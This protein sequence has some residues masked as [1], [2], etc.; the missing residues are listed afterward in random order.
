MC[1]GRGETHTRVMRWNSAQKPQKLQVKY[2]SDSEKAAQRRFAVL[3]VCE[4]GASVFQEIAMAAISPFQGAEGTFM[5]ETRLTPPVLRATPRRGWIRITWL[6]FPDTP[7]PFI[8]CYATRRKRADEDGPSRGGIRASIGC[9]CS[10]SAC[11]ISSGPL[12]TTL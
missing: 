10:S 5:R 11:F 7:V 2:V 6:T 4:P 9:N 1:N 8:N 3:R 12:I